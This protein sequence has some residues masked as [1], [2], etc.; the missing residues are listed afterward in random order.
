MPDAVIFVSFKDMPTDEEL[1][2]A[3]EARCRTLAGE[4]PELTQVEVTITPDGT[5][6]SATGHV[7]GKSTRLATHAIAVEPGHAADQLL[8][9]LRQQLRRA[10]DK[11]IFSRRREAQQ[12][13]P[14]RAPRKR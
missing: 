3:V 8:D 1:R 6:H 10:H 7:N 12:R 5:G 11:R 13:N 14:K 9:T 2:E 4:F